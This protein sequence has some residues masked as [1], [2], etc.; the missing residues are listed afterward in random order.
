MK[1]TR[2]GVKS[3]ADVVEALSKAAAV[4]VGQHQLEQKQE[5]DALLDALTALKND[6]P[7]DVG[8]AKNGKWED[9]TEREALIF[10]RRLATLRER[11]G[12]FVDGDGPS[13]PRWHIM[14][15]AYAPSWVIYLMTALGVAG[16]IVALFFITILWPKAVGDVSDPECPAAAP[17]NNV[18]PNAESFTDSVPSASAREVASAAASGPAVPAP[19]GSAALRR[20]REAR[21]EPGHDEGTAPPAASAT[22][23][24]ADEGR[25]LPAAASATSQ[26]LTQDAIERILD[27]KLHRDRAHVCE[28]NVLVMI[29]LMGTLGGFVH[30]ISS[31]G[32]YVGNRKLMRSWLVWYLLMPVSGATLAPAVYL[33]LRVGVLANGTDHLNLLGLYAFALLTGLFAEQAL[34]MLSKTFQQV[35]AKIDAKDA[36]DGKVPGA[37]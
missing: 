28:Q 12:Q 5:H 32:K 11:L 31:L 20:Y 19:S 15:R 9:L 23:F 22:T 17:A 30:W 4:V 35:F 29:I 3:I 26:P 18:A 2:E 7:T 36:M 37:N 21:R 13:E 10:T 33:L 25:A 14:R 16:S 1:Y 34:E 24:V 8:G 6:L 27:K